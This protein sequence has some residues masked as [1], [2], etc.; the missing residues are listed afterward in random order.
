MPEWLEFISGS[1][2]L[3]QK[4]FEFDRYIGNHQSGPGIKIQ[5]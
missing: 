5:S 2:A 4:I 1:G 3:T